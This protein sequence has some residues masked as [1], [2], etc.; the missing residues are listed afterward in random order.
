[1]ATE[2]AR[3]HGSRWSVAAAATG[4]G[5][6]ALAL[7][8]FLVAGGPSDTSAEGIANYF[9]ANDTAVEW[10]AF[11]FGLSGIFLLWFAGTLASALRA[12]DPDV[13]ARLGGV[14]LA[15]AAAAT[16]LYLV[17]IAGW[18][19]LA[20]L[21]AD[22]T[23]GRFSPEALGDS[24]MIFNLSENSLVLAGFGAATFVGAASLA[25]LS[26][27]MLPDWLAWAGG[28]VVALLV[29]NAFVQLVGGG[30]AGDALGI[31]SFLA[32]V[33]WVL[34]ASILLSRWSARAAAAP[35]LGAEGA[36]AAAAGP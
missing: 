33:A 34:A 20:H 31:G 14:A 23:P 29:V 28:L 35:P 15:G 13:G 11:L 8:A 25:L 24:L 3:V 21:F 2:R 5:F 32:F 9:A 7:I 27:R 36:P 18:T 17:G 10:Q 6:A 12:N 26:A 30:A 4:V 19:T 16:V 22:A 1:M